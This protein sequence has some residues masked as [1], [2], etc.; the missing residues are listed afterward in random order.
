M[1]RRQGE[2]LQYYAAICPDFGIILEALHHP[3]LIQ[4]LNLARPNAAAHDPLAKAIFKG[5]SE[6]AEWL[7]CHLKGGPGGDEGACVE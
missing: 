4:G 1:A 7:E 2:P 3:V 5:R 6:A